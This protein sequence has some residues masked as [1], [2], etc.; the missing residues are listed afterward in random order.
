MAV[1]EMLSIYDTFT[2]PLLQFVQ[3]VK[4]MADSMGSGGMT[5]DALSAASTSVGSS[6]ETVEKLKRRLSQIETD[7]EDKDKTL[8]D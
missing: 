4:G 1:K 7:L 8:L 3:R 2:E 6:S 5:G